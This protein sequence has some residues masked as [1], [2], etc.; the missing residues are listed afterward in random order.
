[1]EA[2]Q[3]KRRS[4]RF[5]SA[6]NTLAQISFASDKKNFKPQILGLAI[7]ESPKGAC[8]ASACD[9]RLANGTMLWI[10]I[11][12]LAVCRAEVCWV[13]ELEYGLAAYGLRYPA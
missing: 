12:K 7:D 11:G 6:P 9:E 2:S 5:K 3:K 4:F 10:K 1:M 8:V 13:K